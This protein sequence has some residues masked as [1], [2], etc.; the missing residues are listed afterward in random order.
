MGWTK[1]WPK[2]CWLLFPNTYLEILKRHRLKASRYRLREG[3]LREFFVQSRCF[4]FSVRVE[5]PPSSSVNPDPILGNCACSKMG[6]GFVVGVLGVLILAHAAYST[7]QYR[8]LL[9]ITEEEFSGPP[10]NVV[11]ELLLGLVFSMWAALTVP[12][13]FLSIY[14]DSEENRIVS[15]PANLDFIIFNHRGKAVS[16][17][18]IKLKH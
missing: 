7:I 4:G 11:V 5:A 14:P 10:I 8:G 1:N 17:A 18:N 3:A 9:K 16:S 13:N 12:G 2:K 6:I 15:L